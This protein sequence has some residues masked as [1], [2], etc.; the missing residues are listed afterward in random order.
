[1][2]SEN[3]ASIFAPYSKLN[4]AAFD[5]LKLVVAVLTDKGEECHALTA[6][7]SIEGKLENAYLV[8]WGK[9]FIYCGR[10]NSY[11]N[12]IDEVNDFGCIHPETIAVLQ[13]PILSMQQVSFMCMENSHFDHC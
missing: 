11:G 13:P 7:M 8:R 10:N 6:E 1:M 5:N 9:H 2:L 3:V 4:L 12:P